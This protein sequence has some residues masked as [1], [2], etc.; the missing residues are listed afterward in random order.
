M[1][2]FLGAILGFVSSLAVGLLSKKLG[3]MRLLKKL[4]QE[5]YSN[6]YTIKENIDSEKRFRIISPIWDYIMKSDVTFTFGAKRYAKI[7]R[8]FVELEAFRKS[9]SNMD[10]TI[11]QLIEKR[12]RF[13]NIIEEN[14]I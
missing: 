9:E 5:L 4:R 10:A 6:Y 2:I 3:A 11:D 7:I 1:E 8:I 13:L 14:K 12:N